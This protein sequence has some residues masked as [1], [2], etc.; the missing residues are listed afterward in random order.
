VKLVD[1]WK[2]CWTWLSI[3]L[4]TLCAIAPLLYE[5][6]DVVQQYLSPTEFSYVSAALGVLTIVGRLIK[7]GES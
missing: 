7:Q 6:V 3:H 1:D 2:K 4:A 5:H